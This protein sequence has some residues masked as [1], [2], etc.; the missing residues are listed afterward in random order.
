M[1]DINE[2]GE[3]MLPAFNELTRDVVGSSDDTDN[4]DLDSFNPEN[5]VMWRALRKQYVDDAL[6]L[7]DHIVTNPDLLREQLRSLLKDH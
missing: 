1:E 6:K 7:I 4:Y 5:V 2:N 3:N